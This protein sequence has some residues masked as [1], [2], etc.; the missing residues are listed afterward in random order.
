ME[1]EQMCVLYCKL[2]CFRSINVNLMLRK[3]DVA[4]QGKIGTV[5][6]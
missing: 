6:V 4:M 3:H 1:K 5:V 2:K